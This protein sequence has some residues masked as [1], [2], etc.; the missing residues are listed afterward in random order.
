[1]AYQRSD[2]VK[3][4]LSAKQRAIINAAKEV[5][6]EHGYEGTSIKE[7]ARRAGVATGT[8][9]LYLRNKEALFNAIIDEVYETV[10]Q[11]IVRERQK[12][13]NRRDKLK[14][15]MA[16]ALQTL[17]K[18]RDLA[19]LVMTPSND[20]VPKVGVHLADLTN[21]LV[22]LVEADLAEAIEAGEIPAQDIHL[23]AVAFVGTF[24]HTFSDWLQQESPVPLH[25]VVETL[26]AYNLRGL[27][28]TE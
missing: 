24:Y 16:A 5:F 13:N 21:R 22:Q 23:A 17:G 1:M 18:H 9:Y 11:E 8:V 14:A 7:I 27:G 28:F 25:H 26:S 2:K 15:S 12:A 6:T 19:R 4:K 20:R 3:E 10:L